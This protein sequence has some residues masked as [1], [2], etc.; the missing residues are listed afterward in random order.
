V[1]EREQWIATLELFA[2]AAIL[3][4]LVVGLSS[5]EGAWLRQNTRQALEEH[6]A[7]EKR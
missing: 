6:E 1:T 5:L 3:Y 4:V 7:G 2:A